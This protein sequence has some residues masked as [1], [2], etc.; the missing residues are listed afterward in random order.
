MNIGFGN[1]IGSVALLLLSSSAM[2]CAEEP[3]RSRGTPITFSGPKSDVVSTN[4]ND[5]RKSATPLQDL[6]SQLKLPFPGFDAPRPEPGF[7]ESR[8]IQQQPQPL[9]RKT[10]KDS[11]NERAED[12]FLNPELYDA[13]KED[14]AI[15][16]LDKLSLDPSRKR[17]RNSFER[18]D[19]QQ[20]R[21]R[22]TLTNRASPNKLFGEKILGRPD[23]LK[24]ESKAFNPYKPE[25]SDVES[26]GSLS[27]FPRIA[28]N[29]SAMTGERSVSLRNSEAFNRALDNSLSRQQTAAN[30][31]MEEFKRILEGP[32]Y[33]PPTAARSATTAATANYLTT[34]PAPPTTVPA[35][36]RSAM[37]SG[38]SPEWSAFKST[39]K[40]EPK[41]DFAKSAGLVGSLEKL[42]GLPEFPAPT[43]TF[44]PAKPVSTPS[45]PVKKN[46]A[47]T[48]KLPQRGF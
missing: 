45:I 26:A 29:N 36:S 21:E 10:I 24:D 13:D 28:T 41:P 35:A 25:Y 15:F 27:A 37:T 39:A 23:E 1:R 43:K 5:L 4:L 19:E 48:F 34:S 31:R 44:E 30:A 20:Q 3:A 6:E 7:R 42:Q 16:Q 18:F 14:E 47:A 8:R 12:M 22:A 46:P 2:I 11:L 32:R 38:S 17:P 9:N 33:T 40:T